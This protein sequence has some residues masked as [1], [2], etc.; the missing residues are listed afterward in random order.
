MKKII[1]TEKAPKAVGPY[2]QAVQTGDL[3]FI[4]GQLPID[5][6]TGKFAGETIEEQTKQSLKNMGEILKEAGM[7]FTNVIKTTVLLADIKDFV[8]MNNIYAEF[9]SQDFPARAAFQVANL[10][11]GAKVEI[12]A[13]ASN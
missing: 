12:E 2:S 9:F 13:I 10:P 7:D 11:L 4:S 1:A 5:S 8:A 3:L 6:A